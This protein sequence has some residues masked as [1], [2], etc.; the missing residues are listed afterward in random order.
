MVNAGK[1]ISEWTFD[2]LVQRGVELELDSI[3]KGEP[4][5]SRVRRIMDLSVQW[6]HEK[7]VRAAGEKI[8]DDFLS[9]KS[10]RRGIRI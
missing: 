9:G 8:A 5:A 2:E 4:L 7:S 6:R 10:G 1:D 3:V